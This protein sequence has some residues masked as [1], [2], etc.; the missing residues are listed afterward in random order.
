[1]VSNIDFV[2]PSCYGIPESMWLV[3]SNVLNNVLSQC[4]MLLSAF[5]LVKMLASAFMDIW[6]ERFSL[7]TQFRILAQAFMI[8][9]F[10]TYYKTFLMTF[11][12]TI[13]SLSSFKP[14]V[15][16][17]TVQQI[18]QI[19]N[20]KQGI[21]EWIIKMIGKGA[22]YTFFNIFTKMGAL[23]FMHYIKSVSLLILAILGPFA[24]LFSLLPGP[25]RSSFKT[26]SKGYI[27]VSCWTITL[28]I[29][30]VLTQAFIASISGRDLW[31]IPLSFVL[32]IMIFFVP[33][34]TTKLISSVNL[35]N[36]AAGVSKAPG[37]I[38]TG[39]GTAFKG[40]K[41]AVTATA[42]GVSQAYKFF[43]G[44]NKKEQT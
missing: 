14:A 8:A 36:I 2:L 31:E 7:G 24:T 9:V 33:T 20:K 16:K 15:M 12:Y 25:F 22:S 11:D 32:L 27:H 5:V 39:T 21:T 44:E 40:T 17:Q 28:A 30:E 18:E 38:V 42:S 29:L 34:W 23:K 41:S 43:A 10:F 3:A 19:T 26:W 1:M 37:S 6:E 13:D 4:W 35:G